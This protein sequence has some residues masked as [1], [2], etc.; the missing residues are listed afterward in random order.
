MFDTCPAPDCNPGQLPL[1]L[2]LP[3]LEYQ[4]PDQL[5]VRVRYG[6]Q[7]RLVRPAVV[8][9]RVLHLCHPP[10]VLTDNG[11]PEPSELPDCL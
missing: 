7:Q 11:E 10:V 4:Q 3:L 6:H 2:Q 8:T 1:L 9:D 5:A